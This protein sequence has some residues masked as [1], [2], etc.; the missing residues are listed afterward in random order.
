M[1]KYHLVTEE[2]KQFILFKNITV[3]FYIS[4]FLPKPG[5]FLINLEKPPTFYKSIMVP[6]YQASGTKQLKKV[7]TN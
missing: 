3:Y 4:T 5:S 7:K 2:M 1:N 6:Y